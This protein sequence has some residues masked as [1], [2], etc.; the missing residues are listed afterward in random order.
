MIPLANHLWQST[1]FAAVAWLLTLAFRNQRA[2]WRY[3]LWLTASL[4]FL[5]PFALLAEA[6]SWIPRNTSHSSEPARHR[7]VRFKPAVF[8]ALAAPVARPCR[9]HDR[10]PAPADPA[11]LGMRNRHRSSR[12]NPTLEAS[13][14]TRPP[15][16]A[17]RA[18]R[19]PS[20]VIRIPN[21][22][23]SL[24]NPPP[25]PPASRRN[26]RSPDAV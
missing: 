1:L 10:L 26:Y 9:A 15:R 21:R 14:K 25:R 24:W 17:L 13:R 12:S 3:A 23:G 11:P 8:H 16:Y 6:G 2:Q 22:A 7:C 4:K 18:C 5:I 20:P 19:H